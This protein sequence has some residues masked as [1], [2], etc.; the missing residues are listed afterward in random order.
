MK[1]S[2]GLPQSGG[3]DGTTVGGAP[4]IGE[5]DC[6]LLS[7]ALDAWAVPDEI[8][9]RI[10]HRVLSAIGPRDGPPPDEPPHTA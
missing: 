4:A 10:L 8:R 1:R 2:P 3:N 6:A 9:S 7:Q 5:H